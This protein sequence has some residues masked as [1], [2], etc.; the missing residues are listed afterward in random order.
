[1]AEDT[2]NYVDDCECLSYAVHKGHVSGSVPMLTH[3]VPDGPWE[4]VSL[5]ILREFTETE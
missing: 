4:K 2:G 1:M 3:G 5:N